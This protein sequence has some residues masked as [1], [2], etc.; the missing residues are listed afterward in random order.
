MFDIGFFE[1]IIIMTIAVLV[2][3]PKNLPQLAKAVGKGW[4]EFQATFEG[5]KD[6]VMEE[7]DNLKTSVNLDQLEQDVSS[8]TKVDVDVN[9]NLDDK[10]TEN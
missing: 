7:A 1:L 8:A 3:G 9:L 5:L 4:K 6:E 2:V 10:P